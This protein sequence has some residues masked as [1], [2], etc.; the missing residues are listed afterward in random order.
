[1]IADSH[2][3]S[4]VKHISKRKDCVSS[5]THLQIAHH[6][7]KF[8]EEIFSCFKS[9]INRSVDCK[10]ASVHKL[11]CSFDWDPVSRV[12]W[13]DAKRVSFSPCKLAIEFRINAENCVSKLPN[14]SKNLSHISVL[15]VLIHDLSTERFQCKHISHDVKSHFSNKISQIRELI[16]V[17]TKLGGSLI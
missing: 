2:I 12:H 9:H 8:D 3:M 4:I 6:M 5:I 10:F 13:A 15:Q 14:H 7:A 17:S 16:N 1:M 11:V